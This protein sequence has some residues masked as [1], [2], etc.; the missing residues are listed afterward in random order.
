ME[1][2]LLS[3]VALTALDPSISTNLAPVRI[4]VLAESD[5]VAISDGMLIEGS[6]IISRRLRREKRDTGAT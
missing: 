2:A 1:T 6:N 5:E 3:L 4:S